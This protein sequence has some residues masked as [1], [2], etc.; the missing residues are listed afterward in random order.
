MKMMMDRLGAVN[1]IMENTGTETK[2]RRLE[3]AVDSGASVLINPDEL[4]DHF[5]RDTV[6]SKAGE[7]NLPQPP[8][9]FRTWEKSAL[10]LTREESLRAVNFT[11]APVAKPLAVVKKMCAVGHTVELDDDGSNVQQIHW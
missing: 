11:V 9:P 10:M 8:V 1:G 2:W 4:S 6:A 7:S 3:V 5:V